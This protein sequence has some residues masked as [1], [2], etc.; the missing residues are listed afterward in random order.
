MYRY[1]QGRRNTSY[2][3]VSFVQWTK[4]N[5]DADSVPLSLV[6][7]DFCVSKR[8]GDSG[9]DQKCSKAQKGMKTK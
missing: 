6:I 7:A 3:H 8:L 1:V 9:I 4:L 2:R 5:G